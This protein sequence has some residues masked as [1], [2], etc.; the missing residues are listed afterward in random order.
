MASS[1][2]D[3]SPSEWHPSVKMTQECLESTEPTQNGVI[4]LAANLNAEVWPEAEMVWGK[5]EPF[6]IDLSPA[7]R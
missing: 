7:H 5:K 2:K 6:Q 4:Y 3:K 1:P